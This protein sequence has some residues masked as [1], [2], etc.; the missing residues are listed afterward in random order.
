MIVCLRP[1]LSRPG[2]YRLDRGGTRDPRGPWHRG[3][4]GVRAGLWTREGIALNAS[5]PRFTPAITRYAT[6]LPPPGRFD[7]RGGHMRWVTRRPPQDGPHR[8]PMADPT[9]HRPW[10]RDPLR[11]TE[12][13]LTVAR[14]EE[15]HSFDA[16]GA[17]FDHRDGRCTFEVLIDHFDL[18]G[19]PALVRLA[20]I[21]HA[22]DIDDQS[23]PTRS[24]GPARHRAGRARRRGGRPAA[25][26]ARLVRLRRPLRLVGPTRRGRCVT[27]HLD[28]E[29]CGP[30]PSAKWPSSWPPRPS[31][32]PS[33]AASCSSQGKHLFIETV[34]VDDAETLHE[35]AGW[36]RARGKERREAIWFRDA[37]MAEAVDAVLFVGLA[38]WYPPN[39]DCGACGYATCAEFLHAT[40]PLRDDS[41]RARVRRTHLQPARHRP[42]HRGRLGRQDRGHPLH[43]LPLP[44]P[45]RRGGPQARH[46][47]RRHRRRPLTVADAQGCRVRPPDRRGRRSTPS[48][49]RPP[50][51]SRSV[52][53][54]RPARTVPA[55]ASNPGGRSDPPARRDHRGNRS[56]TRDGATALDRR[57]A[58]STPRSRGRRR[59]SRDR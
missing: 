50:G 24:S 23:T 1:S 30:T 37:D 54:A 5:G 21:V 18:G 33:R 7:P 3:R 20:A 4:A 28:Y 57:C 59:P 2:P 9:L 27:E 55:T 26:G 31:P 36:L 14:D 38:D 46:H 6:N 51:P 42:R 13:V 34:I 16:P 49:C 58:R 8:L 45:H 19:D 25:A 35:L 15:A 56:P 10:R 29:A 41:A 17:E 12:D 52:S 43:R 53:K 22:A 32:R 40:K 39:Y 44:D 11:T 47:P 48:T